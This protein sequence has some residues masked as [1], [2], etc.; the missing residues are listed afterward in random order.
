MKTTYVTQS[1]DYLSIRQLQDNRA[2]AK[3]ITF[4]RR[5]N[6]KWKCEVDADLWA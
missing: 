2:Y 4:L 3:Q 5:F 6:G 1:K